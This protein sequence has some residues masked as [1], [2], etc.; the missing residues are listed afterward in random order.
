MVRIE[1]YADSIVARTQSLTDFINGIGQ[2]LTSRR[3]V[4]SVCFV[5]LADLADRHRLRKLPTA[6]EDLGRDGTL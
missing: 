3:T 4:E 2:L 6:V 5:P 1:A